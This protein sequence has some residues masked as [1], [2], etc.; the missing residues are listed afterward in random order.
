M[1]L[2]NPAQTSSSWKRLVDFVSALIRTA[3]P[4]V[5][6]FLQQARWLEYVSLRLEDLEAGNGSSLGRREGEG[7]MTGRIVVCLLAAAIWAGG[8]PPL[9]LAQATTATL[10]GTAVDETGAT[11]AN[12]RVT[13]V[14]L[15]T[16]LERATSTGSEGRFIAPLLPPGRYRLDAQRDGFATTRID[17]IVLNVGDDVTVNVL[18]KV[19]AVD[20]TL[21]VM[22]DPSLISTSP[23]VASVVDRQF[24]ADLPLN[25][26]SFQSLISMTPGVVVTTTAFDD[27]GQFSVNGQRANA[28][29]FTIDGVSANFGVTGYIAMVQSAGGT[30]PALSA[31]GGTNGL[32]SVDAMQEFRIQTSSFAPEFGRTS[33]GQVNIVTRSGSNAFHASLFEYFRNDALGASDWFVNYNHLAKPE[34]RFNDFGG[35]VGGPV[36]KDSTFFFFSHESLRLKQPATQQTAVPDDASRLAAPASMRPYLNAYPAANGPSLGSGLAQFNAPYSDPSSLDADSLRVDQTVNGKISVF[37]RFNYSPSSIDQRGR[38]TSFHVL[39]LTNAVS[40]TIRTLTFG[41]THVMSSATTNELRVNFSKQ[42]V[43]TTYR[44][45]NFGG[46][47]PLSDSALFP[48]GYTSANAAFLF[49]I[50]GAGEYSVGRVATNEQRQFNLIDNFST[51]KG[52]HRLKAGIDY[53]W[54]APSS[55]PFAY[56]QYVQFSGVSAD[57]G[58]ALSGTAQLATAATFQPDALRAQNFSLYG[59]DTWTVNPRLTLTYG[60]RWDV[61]PPLKGKDIDNQPFTVTGLDQPATLALAPR[62]TPLY[63]TT[64]GNVAPRIGAV[65]RV[66]DRGRWTTTARASFGVF[67]DLGYGSL[68]GATTYFPYLAI[69]TLSSPMFPLSAQDATAPDLSQ[70]PP[71]AYIVVADPH[72]KLPRTYQWNV[73]VEQVV[74]SQTVSATYIGARGRDLLRVTNLFGVNPD[75]SFVSLTDNSASS[76]YNGLQVKVDRRLSHGLQATASYTLSHSMDNAST[77]AFAN[78][79]NTLGTSAALDRA[80][81]DFDTRHVFTAGVIYMLPSPQAQTILREILGGWSVSGVVSA[82]SA[83][84]VNVV[85]KMFV[86]AGTALYPRPNLVPGVPLELYGSQYPGGKI[87]NPAAFTSAPVGQQGNFGRNVLRGFGA[88]QADV[89][90]Q[91]RFRVAGAANV[92]FRIEAFNVFNTP[93]FASPNNNITDPL[94]GRSTQSLANALGSGG[95]N[96]GLSPLYQLGGPRSIQ[97]ALRLEY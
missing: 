64:Y 44:I 25:G 65:Y 75:F 93:N 38:L 30:L 87:I 69:K 31:S 27:Q 33:G 88:S 39:S 10:E 8:V 7:F 49:Y 50:P 13:L 73:A 37:G 47:Q 68:G 15:A 71:V 79:L 26:R 85:G 60:L 20:Q 41:L 62:G 82:R 76:D 81:S 40:S 36:H 96:G 70:K 90:L 5:H 1:K 78:Y 43:D 12:A 61:N 28:N 21:T 74:G 48:A 72:L 45:D 24:A 56:R 32:V 22:G 9:A 59:Q 53:R 57:A 3:L 66:P 97:L 58:G 55:V 63:S 6:R 35:V 46:A 95:A 4:T 67:Y 92:L 11:V 42:Q 89:A 29:Y 16:A 23:T 17:Q 86:A 34:T 51:Q 14:N 84:P 18:L 77:D 80:D 83:P 54:L 94:F 19:G 2:P 52:G 91:R